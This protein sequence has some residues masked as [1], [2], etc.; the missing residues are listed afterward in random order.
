[1]L[2]RTR[3]GHPPATRDPLTLEALAGWLRGRDPAE[4]YVYCSNGD[5]LLARYLRDALGHDVWVSPGYYRD[6]KN[7][8]TAIPA[9]LDA[10]AQRGERSVGA[11]LARAE[12]RLEAQAAQVERAS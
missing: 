1:M 8:R 11:A 4:T 10:V 9:A 6:E 12:A 3:P 7:Q 5:C 2:Q